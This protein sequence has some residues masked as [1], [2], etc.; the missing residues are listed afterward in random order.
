MCR[1]LAV[2]LIQRIGLVY[3]RPRVAA[4]RYQKGQ[5][6]SIAAN[7]S[8][9][10]GTAVGSSAAGSAAAQAAAAEAQQRAAA[11]AAAAEAEAE[12]DV[13]HAEQLEG[14]K[15]GDGYGRAGWNCFFC[16]IRRPPI[17]CLMR[18]PPAHLPCPPAGVIEALLQGLADR[19]TVVRWSAAKGVGRVTG[20]LPRDLADDVVASLLDA[21]FAQCDKHH[22]FLIELSD[23]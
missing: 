22:L 21:F 9:P 20:R 3:L 19:D 10:S 13:E 15:S 16:C 2:K 11:A 12:E 6:N 17:S 18:G 14:G 4:W 1:K 8:A 7:L 23:A 5:T